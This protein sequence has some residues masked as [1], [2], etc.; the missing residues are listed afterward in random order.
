MVI[1]VISE[2]F[3]LELRVPLRSR[4][5]PQATGVPVAPPTSVKKAGGL[6]QLVRMAGG[7]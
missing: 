5:S 3:S 6:N 7:L 2:T 4:Q 1:L